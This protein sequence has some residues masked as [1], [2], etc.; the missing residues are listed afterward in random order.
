MAHP[1]DQI[2]VDLPMHQVQRLGKLSIEFTDCDATPVMV[3][4]GD[5]SATYFCAIETGT[6]EDCDGYHDLND[7]E[8]KWLEGFEDKANQFENKYK[9]V[10]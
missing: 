3:Y 8:Q 9:D 1:A 2:S 5:A 4:Y 10:A 7:K 6:V